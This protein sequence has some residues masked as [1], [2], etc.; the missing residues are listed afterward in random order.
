MSRAVV[1]RVQLVT[2]ALGDDL[3]AADVQAVE[4]VLRPAGIAPVPGMPAWLLGLLEHGGRS[5]PVVDLRARLEL[6]P[7][8]ADVEPRILIVGGEPD[9]G[10][11]DAH[12]G[13]AAVVDRVVDVAAV[14]V[15]TV[16]PAPPLFRGLSREYVGGVLRRDGRLVVVLRLARLLSATERLAFEQVLAD[17]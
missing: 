5:H 1:E 14:P 10:P 16:D 9:A 3:F 15:S 7:R 17:V 2:F 8:R 11:A 4:R 12:G 13:L 6:P